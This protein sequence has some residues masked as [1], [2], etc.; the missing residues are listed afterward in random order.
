MKFWIL[1]RNFNFS[2]L[3]TTDVVQKQKASGAFGAQGLLQKNHGPH[4]LT[5]GF[6]IVF[7]VRSESP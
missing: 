3:L 7:S 1:I 5:H 2:G 6:R 4:L